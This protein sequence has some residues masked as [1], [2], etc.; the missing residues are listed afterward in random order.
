MFDP[1]VD[2][3]LIGLIGV[4]VGIGG[5]AI[6]NWQIKKSERE[7]NEYVAKRERYEEWMKTFIEGDTYV[8]LKGN[9]IPYDLRVAMLRANTLL[10]LYASDEVIRKVL[11][12]WK[13]K[14]TDRIPM[15]ETII[16]MRKD[17][18]STDLSVADVYYFKAEKIARTEQ[19]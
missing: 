10:M 4:V 12:V 6:Q 18:V 8:A 19:K 7:R 13:G 5:Y 3:A 15:Q 9:E 2:A 1:I 17:L 11:N 14:A 16:A